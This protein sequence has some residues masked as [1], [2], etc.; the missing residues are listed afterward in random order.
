MPTLSQIELLPTFTSTHIAE[1]SISFAVK[2]CKL[3]LANVL[4]KSILMSEKE[5]KIKSN[6]S[7]KNLLV[8]PSQYTLRI[9]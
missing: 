7:R 3:L 5:M 6:S 9:A 2:Y 1:K 4:L 8:F